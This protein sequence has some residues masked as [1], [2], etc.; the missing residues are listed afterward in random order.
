MVPFEAYHLQV[1]KKTTQSINFFA[2]KEVEHLPGQIGMDQKERHYNRSND[3]AMY[4]VLLVLA[5]LQFT[6]DVITISQ[7]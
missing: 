1:S 5:Y 4:I 7:L 2:V 6:L 3:P